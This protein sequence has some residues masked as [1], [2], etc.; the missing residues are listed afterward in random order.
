M[1]NNSRLVNFQTRGILTSAISVDI[2]SV[3]WA[4]VVSNK[5]SDYRVDFSRNFQPSELRRKSVYYKE[6][7]TGAGFGFVD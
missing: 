1:L 6:A 2:S 5:A 4:P 3:K 7:A